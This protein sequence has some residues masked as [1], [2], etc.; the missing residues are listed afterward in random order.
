MSIEAMIESGMLADVD[1]LT[2]QVTKYTKKVKNK[3][4]GKST[5]PA[6]TSADELDPSSLL[7]D[8]KGIQLMIGLMDQVIPAIVVSP[9]VTLHFTKVTV[10]KTTVTKKIALEDREPGKVYTDQVGFEDKV[11]LFDWAAG[12]L[13]SMMKFLG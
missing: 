5:A 6:I 9:E 11:F 10:G 13:G 3:T 8:P 7:K 12:G 4:G 1:T 2:S